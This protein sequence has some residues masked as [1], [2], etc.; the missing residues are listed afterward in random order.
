MSIPSL[1]VCMCGLC[2][3]PGIL[4]S[5]KIIIMEYLVNISKRRA[6]WSLNEDI[7]KITILTTNTSYPSRKIRRIRACTHQRPQRKQFQYA[8]SSEDQYAVLE[9]YYVNILEDIKRGLYSKKP[10]YAIAKYQENRA[11]GRNE[12]RIVAIE[13]SNSKALVATDNNEDI[14]W[15]K[16]FDAEPVTYAMM[17]LTEFKKEDWSRSFVQTMCIWTRMDLGFYSRV[18]Q[19][20]LSRSTD[21]SYYPRMDNRRPRISSY[22]PSSSPLLPDSLIEQHNPRK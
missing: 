14:D 3:P 4:V 2:R 21:G 7:L 9:I 12:K 1:R 13:D 17:A 6:F 16:E 20:V 15:T 18:P 22:S 8:I 19:A 5:I 11:N 10:Q